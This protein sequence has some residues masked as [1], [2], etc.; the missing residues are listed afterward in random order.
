MNLPRPARWIVLALLTVGIAACCPD[1]TPVVPAE[2][3]AYVIQDAERDV[4]LFDAAEAVAAARE[5]LEGGDAEGALEAVENAEAAMARA[6]TA[7]RPQSVA[8]N[9]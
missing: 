4:A 2:G 9:E 7:F 8:V 1:D 5:A 6:D 3:S